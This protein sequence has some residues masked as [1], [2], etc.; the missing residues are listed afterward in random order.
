MAVG[1]SVTSLHERR[2]FAS[3]ESEETSTTSTNSYSSY[4]EHRIAPGSALDPRLR[5]SYRFPSEL[6]FAVSVSRIADPV[7]LAAMAGLVTQ[8]ERPH[9][10]AD[11]SLSAG[12]VANSKMTLTASGGLTVPIEDAGLPSASVG[13]GAR[14]SRGSGQG[15]H[16]SVQVALHIQGQSS[17]IAPSVS[18]RGRHP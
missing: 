2:Q 10:W 9:N 5:F 13:L 18:I 7:V 14:Y 11:V 16:L 8:H 12:L 17:W 15:L 6:G 1:R 3:S 4:Y